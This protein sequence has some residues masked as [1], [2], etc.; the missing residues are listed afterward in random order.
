[1]TPYRIL[2][3]RSGDDI[4]TR[5]KGKEGGKLLIER[6]MQMKVTTQITHEGMRRDVLIL[7]D[8]LDHTN[9]SNTKIP[10]DWVATFLTP[11]T[12]TV[13][14]YLKQK[15]ADDL[16]PPYDNLAGLPEVSKPQA[17]PPKN[18][19]EENMIR[20]ALTQKMMEQQRFQDFIQMNMAI[21]PQV[22]MQMLNQGLLGEPEDI[23]EEVEDDDDWFNNNDRFKD[24]P[25]EDKF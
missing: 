20:D 4:I 15:E 17:T 11:D 13:D 6:P 7:R 10:E 22:F 24:W 14:L 25:D 12:P 23:D 5:I 21:P 19:A 1:M 18:I 16:D 2:K 3:L 9:E 8:W